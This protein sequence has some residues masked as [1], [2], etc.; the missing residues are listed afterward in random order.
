M[1]RFGIDIHNI[2]QIRHSLVFDTI[3]FEDDNPYRENG[4]DD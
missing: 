3:L 1:N 2:F 4:N